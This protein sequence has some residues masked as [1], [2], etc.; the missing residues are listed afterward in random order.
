MRL[1]KSSPHAF[2]TLC[3]EHRRDQRGVIGALP[4]L[5]NAE[6]RALN[7]SRHACFLVKDNHFAIWLCF[8][9]TFAASTAISK[10]SRLV[11]GAPSMLI[12]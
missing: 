10:M 5:R 9:S 7:F 4:N 1:D 2:G 11:R 12:P 3:V 6:L 8:L